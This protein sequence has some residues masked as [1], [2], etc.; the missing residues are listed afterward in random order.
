MDDEVSADQFRWMEHSAPLLQEMHA[1]WHEAMGRYHKTPPE[2]IAE[3]DDTTAANNIR[4]HMWS[5]VIR[6]FDG[7][8][9][10][11]Y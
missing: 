1:G 5:E 8:P 3:H 4:S 11:S 10:F 7:R 6:R 9:G 2:L